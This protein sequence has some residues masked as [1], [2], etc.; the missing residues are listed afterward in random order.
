MMLTREIAQTIVLETS[1]R[2]N[3]NINIMDEKGI[4]I[5]SGD[6]SRIDNIHEGALVF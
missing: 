1:L 3:R 4:I 6:P 2:L 5:A